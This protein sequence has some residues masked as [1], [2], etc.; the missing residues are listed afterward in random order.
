MKTKTSPLKIGEVARRAGVSVRTLHYYEEIGLL[1]PVRSESGHRLY[2]RAAIERLQQIRS[3]QQLGLSLSEIDALLRGQSISPERIVADHIAEV[4]AQL[5]TLSV[6]ETQLKHLQRLLRGRSR[7]DSEVIPVFLSTLEAMTMY[8][9]HLS[10]EQQ[11]EINAMHEAAGDAGAAWQ[12]ALDGLR[13]EMEAGTDPADARVKALVDKWHEA[14]KSFMPADD[15]GLHQS[16]MQLLHDEPKARQEHGLDDDLFAYLG[17]ALAPG[18][19][20]Q[21]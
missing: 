5:E 18:E 6:L 9:R 7:D 21:T 11:Q 3:L 12:A 14:A 17:R 4:Q 2:G 15:E 10:K 20:P 16:V 8:E 1:E 19:H 13:A